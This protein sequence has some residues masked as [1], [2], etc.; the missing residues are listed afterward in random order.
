M[1]PE[2]IVAAL[3]ALAA[4]AAGLRWLLAYRRDRRGPRAWRLLL[5]LALQPLLAATLYLVLF[6][7]AHPLAPA[8]LT[9]LTAGATGA[10]AP[11]AD[12]IV[13]A[14]PEAAAS[15]GVARIPDLAG[16]LRA[17][18]GTAR[19]RVVGAG[20][21]PRDR[22]AA[23][24]VSIA[25]EPPPLPRGLVRMSPPRNVARGAVFAVAG[26]VEGV[27]EGRVELL[28]P[29]G[30]RV[31]AAPLAEAGEFTLRGIA[32]ES[33]AASFAV[34]VL[35]ND[36]ARVDEAS[37]PLWIEPATPPRVLLLAGA[38]NPETRALRRWLEDAGAKVQARIAVG[39]GLQ[40]GA[41]SLSDESLADADL[42]VVD[43]RAWAG[44]GEGGRGRVLDA[45]R[46][47]LG[48]LLRADTPLPGSSL[49]ALRAT[50]F[51]VDGGTGTQPW[52]APAWRLDDED[53]LRARVGTGSRDA[54]FDLAQAEAPA[55][56]LARRAWRV[57]GAAAL[58][59]APAK[60]APAGW[61][62]S[63]GRGRVGVWT[64]LDSYVLPLHGRADIHGELW[65]AAVATLSRPRAEVLPAIDAG[66]RV[67]QRLAICGWPDGAMIETPDGARVQPLVDPAGGGR[68]CAGFWPQ[69]AG[70]HRLRVGDA[71]RPFH[72]A[73]AE[74]APG[75]RQAELREATLALASAA[76]PAERAGSP[77]TA[78]GRAWPW[79]LAWLLLAA[80]AW[81]LERA[82]AG[83]AAAAAQQDR[84]GAV[85]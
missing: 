81:W 24:T 36:G 32:F 64:L 51:E 58:P 27:P 59:L 33:G 56:A 12:G 71:V 74:A 69:A 30:R 21:V 37:L 35:G 66:A 8:T 4:V 80:A 48:L 41:A 57:R 53:A 50:G 60:D 76:A 73:D 75:L 5:L 23:R 38:P 79:F 55:P 61:W 43:A 54:P 65:S 72:V 44:L 42:L 67:D 68:R 1:T 16:A 13:L 46:D 47:G 6:P 7:P 40:L 62:R 34:R 22:E 28:D 31:D 15:A 39:G 70:W 77:P 29:S 26:R 78:P 25:F 14:L 45:V 2:R 11:D 83:F 18:P 3:L 17:H 84:A 20:L 9:V 85:R 82:R 49:R 10:D 63:E 19:V 52:Q